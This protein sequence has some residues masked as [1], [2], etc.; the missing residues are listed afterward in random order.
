MVTLVSVA[1]VCPIKVSLAIAETEALPQAAA[2]AAAMTTT[3][4]QLRRNV[5]GY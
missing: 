1:K 3:S 4:R 5:T 2:A